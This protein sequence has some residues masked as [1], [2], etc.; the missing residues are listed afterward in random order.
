MFKHDKVRNN[1]NK[2]YSNQTSQSILLEINREYSL[3]RLM[4]K[5]QYFGHLK[6]R[7]SLLE[8]TL[9]LGKTEGRR[10]VQQRLRWLGNITD[11]MTMSLNKLWERVED[12]GAQCAA[13][14]GHRLAQDL[15]T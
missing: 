1:F 4:L 3:Q 5:L 12:R 2:I 8:N 15:M 10:R 7:A 9:M 6:R 13:G 14:R 11:S